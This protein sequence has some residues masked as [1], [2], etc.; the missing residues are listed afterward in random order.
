MGVL[1]TALANLAAVVVS[2]VTSYTLDE[3]PDGLTRAQLPALVIL[4]ELGGDWPGLEPN[5]FSAG[6]GRL[7]VQV[8]HVLLL[9]PVTE[10]LG[11]R[12]ALPALAEAIDAYAGA[13]AADPTLDGALPV[14]L[15]CRVRAGMVRFS[16]VDYHGATFLHT[17]TLQV[18]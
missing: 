17:W 18:G 5:T 1:A 2:G 11:L 6:D 8:A 13:M 9:A 10:G 4:P 3:T 14:A 15:R 12:S 16:G 7:T